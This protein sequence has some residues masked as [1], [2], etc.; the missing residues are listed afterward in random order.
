MDAEVVDSDTLDPQVRLAAWHLYTDERMLWVVPLTAGLLLFLALLLVRGQAQDAQRNLAQSTADVVALNRVLPPPELNA[1]PDY[2][3]AELLRVAFTGN[4]SEHPESNLS[5]SGE[6]FSS[7]AMKAFLAGN[8]T[9]IAAF[10][11]ASLKPECDWN[12]DHRAGF[13]LPLPHLARMRSAARLLVADARARAQAGDH[14]GAADNLAAI[15]RMAGHVGDSPL[16]ISGLVSTAMISLAD[17]ALENIIAWSPPGSEADVEHYRRTLGA[18]RDLR[19]QLRRQLGGERAIGL[20]TFDQLHSRQIPAGAMAGLGV[21]GGAP[22]EKLTYLS[23]GSDRECYAAIMAE[24]LGRIDRNEYS[25]GMDVDKLLDK[26]QSGP[27]PLTNLIL[28]VLDRMGISYARCEDRRG[29]LLAALAVLQH[30]ARLRRDVASLDELVSTFLSAVPNGRFD[31]RP[32]KMVVDPCCKLEPHEKHVE[33]LFSGRRVIRVFSLGENRVDDGGKGSS[34]NGGGPDD[35]HIL[36]LAAEPPA[37]P[38][39]PKTSESV[40]PVEREALQE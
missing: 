8:A 14:T 4:Q 17:G 37:T 28:P 19:A 22:L 36:I 27:A 11:A 15:N 25:F 9:A 40:E 3:A 23:Y 24:M 6:F 30:R 7:T 18:E 29:L 33:E 34:G 32:L 26:H 39:S 13:A 21:G 16:I 35:P 5:K 38:D 12:L 20:F 1:A 2:A 31:G 10:K